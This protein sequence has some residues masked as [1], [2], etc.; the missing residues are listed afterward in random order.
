MVLGTISVTRH[1]SII[2]TTSSLFSS[3][4][5]ATACNFGFF[6]EKRRKFGG[7]G[8]RSSVDEREDGIESGSGKRRQAYRPSVIE[9]ASTSSAVTNSSGSAAVTCTGSSNTMVVDRGFSADGEF[10]VWEKIGAIVTVD[11]LGIRIR[12]YSLPPSS[13]RR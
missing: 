8:I 11:I 5:I 3:S 2:P 1:L 12:S 7:L 9:M 10:P 6:S 13:G 4:T